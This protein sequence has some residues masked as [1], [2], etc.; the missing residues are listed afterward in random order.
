VKYLFLSL[1]VASYILYGTVAGRINDWIW[2]ALFSAGLGAINT[3]LF[4]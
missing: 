3:F 1:S 4:T 2:V